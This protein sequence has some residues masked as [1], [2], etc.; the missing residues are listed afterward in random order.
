MKA[1]H[2]PVLLLAGFLATTASATEL[3]ATLYKN[4]AC[5]CCDEYARLLR[6][7][8]LAAKVVE[9]DDLLKIKTRYGVPAELESCHTTVIGSGAGREYVVEGH[10]PLAAVKR[11]IANKPAICGIGMPVGSPGMGGNKTEPFI[12]YELDAPKKVYAVE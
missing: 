10:V 8:G 7:E 11:L 2:L 6:K 3:S 1:T 5:T 4:P 9:T 12:V